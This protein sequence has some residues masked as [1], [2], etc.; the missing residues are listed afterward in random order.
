MIAFDN[1][2][3]R[4]GGGGFAFF[5]GL[6]T[7]ALE[8]NDTSLSSDISPSINGISARGSLRGGLGESSTLI[9]LLGSVAF[10]LV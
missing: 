10:L 2:S 9:S 1:E 5:G 4:G 7:T 3:F 6:E 8:G